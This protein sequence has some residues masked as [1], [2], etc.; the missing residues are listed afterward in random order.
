M[1][2]KL[3]LDSNEFI[4]LLGMRQLI[5]LIIMKTNFILAIV[6]LLL[7]NN[8]F[9]QSLGISYKQQ[10]SGKKIIN[11]ESG[12]PID[13]SDLQQIINKNPNIIFE[14]IIDKYGEIDYFEVDPENKNSVYGRD[15]SKRTPLGE[16][17]PPFVMK[18]IKNKMLDSDKLKGKIVL[19]QFQLL[20]MEPFFRET[21]L[22]D[23]NDLVSEFKQIIDIQAIVVTESSKNEIPNHIAT[24]N[25]NFEIVADG[26]NF[27]HKYLVSSIPTIVLIDK[28][29]NLIN[30]YNQDEM[31]KLKSDIHRIENQH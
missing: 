22:R 9:S 15:I 29:G 24:N 26:R 31:D 21:T 5:K 2:D 25:Y 12:V 4:D 10:I 28:N 8:S 11:K 30:Y 18:S 14:P 19:L 16:Q 20:F 6:L 27:N 1:N 7:C 13:D 17:F 23:F 3:F